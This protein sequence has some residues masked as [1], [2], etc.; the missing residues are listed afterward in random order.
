M[1]TIRKRPRK[2]GSVA[3]HAQVRLL[4]HEPLTETFDRRGDAVDWVR[5]TEQRIKVGELI[6]KDMTLHDALAD[7]LRERVPK[8]KGKAREANRVK[9]WQREP[10]AQRF[11]ARVRGKDL[12]AY[13]DRRRSEGVADAT[14]RAELMT[15]S[16]V[17]RFAVKELGMES[18]RNPVKAMTLPGSS[19][20][21]TRR[22]VDDE[23]ARLLAALALEGPYMAPVAAFAIE[24]AM[25]QSE[26]LRLTWA[27]VDLP[28]GIASIAEAKTKPRAVPLSPRAREILQALPRSL[29]EDAPIFPLR[30]DDLIRAFRRAC[31]AAG[32]ENLRFHDL[33]R[34]AISRLFERGLSLPQVAA[35][36]G[37][38][39]WSQLK[40]YT[41]VKPED[42]V[43]QL[44]TGTAADQR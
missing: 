22:L 24:T 19:E 13:R 14:I 31:T 34:E 42:L 25:R 41:E 11:L 8:L 27:A 36:S 40:R 32:I 18:L 20:E 10:L 21:R 39:T 6:A 15:V 33:R 4:G 37:H 17:Y 23:E 5:A 12:A 3:W 29:R 7:Y 28:A 9:A 2:D 44:S 1:G 43:K 30:Q 38:S 35:I 26:I 16:A